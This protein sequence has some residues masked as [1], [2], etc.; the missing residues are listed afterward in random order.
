MCW[1]VYD[2]N[3][4]RAENL[5]LTRVKKVQSSSEECR[6]KAAGAKAAGADQAGSEV[7]S[8]SVAAPAPLA[9]EE[10]AGRSSPGQLLFRRWLGA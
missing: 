2:S 6:T 1:S 10:I 7:V 3:A 8:Q 4:V 5:L 9:I